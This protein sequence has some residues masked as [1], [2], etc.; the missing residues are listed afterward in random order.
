MTATRGDLGEF[1]RIARYLRPLAAGFPGALD[2]RDDAAL[3]EAPSGAR[4][5]V[6]TDTIVAGVHFLPDDGPAD[7]AVKALRVN[8]SDLAAMGAAPW[9]YTLNLA[10]PESVDD[11]WVGA[12]A[13]SLAAEQERFA[14]R[15]AGG[16]S[17]GTPGPTTISVTAIGTVEADQGGGLRRDGARPGDDLWV[18]GTIGD[19]ALGLM[20][21]RGRLTGP[22]AEALALRY[23]RP[24]PRLALGARLG[25]LAHA[26]L[27]V[28]DGLIAD[29]EHMAEASGVAL[30]VAT[31]SVPLSSEAADCVADDPDIFPDLL[32][33]GDDYELAFAAPSDRRDA[34]EAAGTETSTRVT[35][36]G[37][38]A[39]TDAAA[40]GV[41]A[42]DADGAPV[43]FASRGYRHR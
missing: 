3:L 5:A 32:T 6:T 23:R 30:D 28:S 10:L 17:V 40:P 11:D 31:A 21:A 15:L 25:G 42:R 12:F 2:L 7:V 36:I 1:G 29:L 26:A 43:V 4:L 20:A 13:E 19:G 41:T 18:S 33:G 27:D 39:E 35:R 38:V 37:T 24:E 34:V 9:C 8:L 14:I 16:D 22:G